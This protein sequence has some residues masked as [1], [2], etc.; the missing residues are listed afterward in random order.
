[1]LEAWRTLICELPYLL[2]VRKFK[3]KKLPLPRPT[4]LLTV[5]LLPRDP[6]Q[7]KSLPHTRP[8]TQQQFQ[9]PRMKKMNIS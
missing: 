1:M 9:G 2:K 4:K 7:M 3:K 8:W 5:K 6:L